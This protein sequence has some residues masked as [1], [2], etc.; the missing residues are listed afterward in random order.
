LKDYSGN[1]FCIFSEMFNALEAWRYN[2]SAFVSNCCFAFGIWKMDT[3]LERVNICFGFET[4][5]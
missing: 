2:F 3:M 5:S 1:I 4:R